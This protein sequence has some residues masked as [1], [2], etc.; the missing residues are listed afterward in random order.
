VHDLVAWCAILPALSVAR[1]VGPL[2]S[3]YASPC[4]VVSC[5]LDHAILRRLGAVVE[6]PVTMHREPDGDGLTTVGTVGV[7][8]IHVRGT[9]SRSCRSVS[10][11][12]YIRHTLFFASLG[13]GLGSGSGWRV[14]GLL[15]GAGFVSGA[16][17][18]GMGTRSCMRR[19]YIW[20]CDVMSNARW[21]V[22]DM[23]S[24]SLVGDLAVSR[25][26]TM[27]VLA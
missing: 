17:C 19:V 3:T 22:V 7:E 2:S 8:V 15:P 1:R 20:V 6:N 21:H 23:Y 11:L 4:S 9:A 5:R 27:Y 14:Y 25:Q 13:P 18:R 12:L 24:V 16:W 10:V 26:K